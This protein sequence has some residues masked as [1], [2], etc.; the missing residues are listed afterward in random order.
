MSN[1]LAKV[2]KWDGIDGLLEDENGE[3]IRFTHEDIH[4][5]D[6]DLIEIGT[7][8]RNDGGRFYEL[9]SETFY[10][11]IDESFDGAKCSHKKYVNGI[12][13]ACGEV[14]NFED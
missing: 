10:H 12:C 7:I 8:L 11:Y 9:T 2:I 14:A 13:I 1:D 6:L 3:I 4:P 5:H